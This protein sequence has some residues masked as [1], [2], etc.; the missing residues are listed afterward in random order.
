[1]H[2]TAR[3]DNDST[4]VEPLLTDPVGS[5]LALFDVDGALT[6]EYLLARGHCCGNRCR[7]CPY[8]WEAVPQED[9]E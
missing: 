1:M 9:A 8:D 4:R 3:P 6:R 5:D 7:N 2:D